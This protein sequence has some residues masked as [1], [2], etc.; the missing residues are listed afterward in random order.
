MLMLTETQVKIWFQNRRMKWKRSKKA[1]QESKIKREEKK[2][3]IISGND[4]VEDSSD[5]D[6]M[7]D[8]MDG[9]DDEHSD[10]DCEN[11]DDDDDSADLI[12]VDG[13]VNDMPPTLNTNV[14]I[15]MKTPLLD[16]SN[17][18]QCDIPTDLSMRSTNNNTVS[19]VHET[20]V[21]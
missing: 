10:L 8:I 3:G 16:H 13:R 9:S 18:P 11:D 2:A 19:S 14:N 15:N 12:D 1:S 17:L 4:K 7:D 6:K 5:K 21:R 20:L